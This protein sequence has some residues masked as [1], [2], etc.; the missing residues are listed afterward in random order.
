[1]HRAHLLACLPK[2]TLRAFEHYMFSRSHPP[3]FFPD[4]QKDPPLFYSLA[5]KIEKRCKRFKT[6]SHK[7]T[8]L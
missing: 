8:I 1:M 5:D 4:F 7:E 3:I 6:N 2:S